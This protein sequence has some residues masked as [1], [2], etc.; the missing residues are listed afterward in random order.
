MH[1]EQ[2]GKSQKRS[3]PKH[4]GCPYVP[5]LARTAGSKAIW[6]QIWQ[7]ACKPLRMPS[8]GCILGLI[9]RV[10]GFG[11]VWRRGTIESP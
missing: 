8:L 5:H 6:V 7:V 3:S 9:T 4:T 1:R 2:K 11:E 10:A